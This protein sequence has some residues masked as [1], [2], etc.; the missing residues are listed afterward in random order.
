M[1]KPRFEIAS[2]ARE[3][4]E[5]INLPHEDYPLRVSLT[6]S[7]INLIVEMGNSNI[8]EFL[9]RSIHSV[10]MFERND[11]GCYRNIPVRVGTHVPPN[12]IDVPRLMANLLP[13]LPESRK[14][15]EDFYVEFETIHPFSD[16]NGRVGGIVIAAMHM[17]M[18]RTYLSPFNT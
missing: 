10:I 15:L 16:G 17:L 6:E 18:F 11:R 13:T 5:W 9:L 14:D 12:P 2:S 7:T 3:A 4:S 8:S 1:W